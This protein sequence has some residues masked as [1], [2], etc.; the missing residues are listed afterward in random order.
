MYAANDADAW[1]WRE[2]LPWRPSIHMPRWASRITLLVTGVR[3]ERVQEITYEDAC[4][5]GIEE[6]TSIGPC[7]AMGWKDYSGGP[8]FFDPDRSFQSLWSTIHAADGPHGW[9]AN[10]WV[11]VVEFEKEAQRG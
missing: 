1:Q 5:E 10:P 11:W 3:V 6:V 7:R 2:G 9:A 4:K 8:G